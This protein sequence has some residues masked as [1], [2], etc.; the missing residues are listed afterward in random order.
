MAHTPVPPH[1]LLDTR[2]GLGAPLAPLGAGGEIGLTVVGS[3]GVPTSARAVVLNV[4]ATN[5][6]ADTFI[7]SYP[8]GSAGRPLRA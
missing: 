8:S 3:A 2:T 5:A 1:R 7:T 6:T 4:T